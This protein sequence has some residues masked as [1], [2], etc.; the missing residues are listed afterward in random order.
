MSDRYNYW[1]WVFGY[2]NI[3]AN[4][5]QATFPILLWLRLIIFTLP[6]SD[7]ISYDISLSILFDDKSTYSNLPIIAINYVTTVPKL[8]WPNPSFFKS[9]IACEP[10]SLIKSNFLGAKPCPSRSCTIWVIT[11][12]YLL[13]CY[14]SWYLSICLYLS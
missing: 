6:S 1:I 2:K 5:S 4:R 9:S 8:P 10:L 7:T 14:F 12:F 13:N 11:L 3:S